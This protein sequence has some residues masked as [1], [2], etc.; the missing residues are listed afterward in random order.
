[1]NRP[2]DFEGWIY[3][4]DIGPTQC[5]ELIQREDFVTIR[6]AELLLSRLKFDHRANLRFT[7]DTGFGNP[8]HVSVG[9]IIQ[10][11]SCLLEERPEQHGEESQSQ[12][13]KHSLFGNLLQAEC[14]QNQ[15]TK[16]QDSGQS[17]QQ[18][19]RLA[20]FFKEDRRDL[21]Q[22]ASAIFKIRDAFFTDQLNRTSILCHDRKA[23]DE[24]CDYR[25][26]N[27]NAGQHHSD[28]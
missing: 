21:N 23:G 16:G 9:K 22:W 10:A 12:H 19:G 18:S 1:M 6:V 25:N 8:I 14:F 11:A 4:I 26:D 28:G 15:I 24:E 17:Q 27:G 2:V 13:H 20:D 3:L 5:V 7:H